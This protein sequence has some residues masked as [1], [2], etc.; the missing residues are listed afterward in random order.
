MLAVIT[1]HLG[2][3]S[4]IAVN[5]ATDLDSVI[6]T[7]CIAIDDFT[8][9]VDVPQNVAIGWMNSLQRVAKHEMGFS[10][11]AFSLRWEPS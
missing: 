9:A 5:N 4:Q 3:V 8:S 11:N 2:V 7:C 1:N 6:E 10:C